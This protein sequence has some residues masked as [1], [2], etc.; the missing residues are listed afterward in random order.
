MLL[1][2][3]GQPIQSKKADDA[4]EAQV[5][6]LIWGL[7][8][9]IWNM[10]QQALTRD[11]KPLKGKLADAVIEKIAEIVVARVTVRIDAHLGILPDNIEDDGDDKAKL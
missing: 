7:E 11:L 4:M 8:Q 3:D 5:N 2:L 9:K 1:W 10:M 6:E